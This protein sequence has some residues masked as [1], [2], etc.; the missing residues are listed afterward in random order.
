MQQKR[1][2]KPNSI[3]KIDFGLVFFLRSTD[4]IKQAGPKQ[5]YGINAQ[6]KGKLKRNRRERSTDKWK[7]N[8]HKKTMKNKSIGTL[9]VGVTPA[10]A[11]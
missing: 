7:R 11:P 8:K 1:G 3:L 2:E 5:N 9:L 10:Y 6:L 4:L